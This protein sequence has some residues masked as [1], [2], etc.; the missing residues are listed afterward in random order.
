MCELPKLK[1]WHNIV[2][3][4]TANSRLL[5]FGQCRH[6]HRSNA[7]PTTAAFVDCL[8]LPMLSRNLAQYRPYAKP[9]VTFT[10]AS[11]GLYPEFGPEL[12]AK[13]I[14]ELSFQQGHDIGN[15]SSAT[16][17]P[18]LDQCWA[19]SNFP[20]GRRWVTWIFF[21]RTCIG[22]KL[23]ILPFFFVTYHFMNKREFRLQFYLFF[24]PIEGTSYFKNY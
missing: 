11:S 7:G 20:H 14:P 13:Y 10:M 5:L 4:L 2:P 23:L 3:I 9:I 1:I 24:E 17:L 15:R 16:F 6:L 21:Y 18:M 19:V 12:V 22:K 8:N